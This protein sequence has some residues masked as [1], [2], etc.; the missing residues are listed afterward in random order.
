VKAELDAVSQDEN[1]KR[2]LIS[3]ARVDLA[4]N[5][6][7]TRHILHELDDFIRLITN[8]GKPT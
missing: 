7:V 6:D 8:T 2:Q 5:I 1:L 4:E 3:G